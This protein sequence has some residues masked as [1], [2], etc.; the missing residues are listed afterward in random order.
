MK[1]TFKTLRTFKKISETTLYSMEYTADYQ[2]DRLLSMGAGSDTEFANNVCKIL[3]NGFPVKVKPEG[4]CSTFVA[5][6]PDKHSLFA[7]NF[8]YKSG[9]AMLIKAAPKNGYRS[10]ALS[11]LGHIGFDKEHLPDKG[12][13]SKFRTLASVYSPLDGMNE[14]GFA[15][16]V[17]TA[18][19]QVTRQNT[20]KTPVMTTLAIRVLLDRAANVEEGIGILKSIDMNS[21]GKIGYHFQMADRSGD[22]AIVEYLDNEMIVIRKKPEDRSFC[23]T[24]FTLSTEARNGTGK[25]RFEIMD[26]RLKEKGAVM[27]GEEAM[28]LLDEARMDG[29][30]Y[31]EPGH[32]YYDSITQWSVI[33]DLSECTATVALKSV[34]DKKYEF[35]IS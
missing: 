17:N 11:N 24:N 13:I 15:V 34:F 8:D 30:K 2:L 26:K 27:S 14:K 1:G 16:A 35:S 4:A 22:S 25:E 7:R 3:L 10:I 12:I 21:S 6:T 9:M 28:E 29:H 33:Y 31:Y 20:G 5:S 23:L 19:E 18:A 32:M